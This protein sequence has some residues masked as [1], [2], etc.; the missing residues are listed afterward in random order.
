MVKPPP[1]VA[2]AFQVPDNVELLCDCGLKRLRGRPGEPSRHTRAAADQDLSPCHSPAA[3]RHGLARWQQGAS[4]AGAAA[5]P[6]A[7]PRN[8]TP[9]LEAL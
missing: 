1:P 8:A 2:V 6:A 5:P 7:S 3:L 4:G 9:A